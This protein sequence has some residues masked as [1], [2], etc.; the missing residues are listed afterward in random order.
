[1]MKKILKYIL[2]LVLLSI[3]GVIAYAL[4]NSGED[5]GKRKAIEATKIDWMLL[6][7]NDSVPGVFEIKVD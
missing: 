1:M 7:E 5:D 3:V 4:L 2:L 6:V